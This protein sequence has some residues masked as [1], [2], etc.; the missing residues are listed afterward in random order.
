MT[1]LIILVHNEADIQTVDF[2]CYGFSADY[3]GPIPTTAMG[4][5]A[6][7]TNHPQDLAKYITT[8]LKEGAMLALLISYLSHNGA[9][10]NLYSQGLKRI[11]QTTM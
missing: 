8:E 11:V 3:A 6:S 10:S 2:L 9:R 5:H 7:V 4:N 1:T